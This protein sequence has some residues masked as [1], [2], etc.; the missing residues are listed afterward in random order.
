MNELVKLW[1]D[2]P[3]GRENAITY[4]ELCFKWGCNERKVR[5][6]LH[7]L[8]GCDT[9]DKYILIRSSKGKG[10]YKTDDVAEIEKYKKE[11]MNRARHT[12]IPLRKINRVLDIN[13]NQVDMFEDIV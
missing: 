6:I 1:D 8:S 5:A 4:S 12:F 9:G 2:I 11:C 3:I 10:F 7:E 13:D